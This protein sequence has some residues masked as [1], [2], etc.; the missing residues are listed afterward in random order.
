MTIGIDPSINGTGICIDGCEYY[1]IVPKKK[2]K[3]ESWGINIIEYPNNKPDGDDT[4]ELYKS[5]RV[6][7]IQKIIRDIIEQ[8]KPDNVVIEA[9]AYAANGSIDMLA[10]LNYSIRNI[11]F[12][13]NIPI[14]IISPT[15]L[16]KES[17]GMGNASKELM[18]GTWK[19]ITNMNIDCDDLA[20]AYFLSKFL[21]KI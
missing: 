21:G 6:Y 13:L 3:M 11:C 7:H 4:K 15:T 17:V 18:L 2:K 20:D 9:I 14:R 19:A 8:Y 1:Y 16:K 12:D 5:I 10:G